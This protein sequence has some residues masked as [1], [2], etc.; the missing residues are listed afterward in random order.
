MKLSQFVAT[1]SLT[2]ILFSSPSIHAVNN[3]PD[4]MLKIM[5]QPKYDHAI[6]GIFV[7]DL[8]TGEVLY[9]QNSA[10]MFSPASTTKLLSISVLLQTLGADYRFKT[11]VYANGGIKDG[12][13]LG[14]LILVAQGDLTMGGRQSNADT[15]SFTKMDHL[16]ANVAPDAIL[17]KEDPLK[18]LDDLAKQVL[19]NGVKE[20]EGDVLIDDRLFETIT[21]RDMILSPIMIN[22]NVIDIVLNPSSIDQTANLMWRPEVPGYSVDNQVKTV[23]KDGPFNIEVTADESGH[24]ILVKGTLPISQHDV[25]KVSPVHDPKA[26]ARDAF[27]QALEKQG[28]KVTIAPKINFHGLPDNYGNQT[29]IALYTSPPLSEYAKL[30]LKVSHNLGADLVPLLLSAHV[31]KKTYDEGMLMI[32][33]FAVNEVKLSPDSFVMMDAAGGNEN[34]FTLQSEIQILEYMHKLA[35]E[36]FKKFYDALPILGVDGSLE[37]FGK[38][39]PAS[40]KVRAKPGTGV[41]SNFATGKLFLITQALAGYIEGKNGHPF[42]YMVVVNNGSLPTINDIFQIFEDQGKLSGILY[43]NT[44]AVK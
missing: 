25:V 13:L 17:T 24:K 30:I 29:K 6:W 16:I 2:A 40:G 43:N 36:E 34:R 4:D 27:I 3:L 39:I 42:A 21:K 19:Q 41:S 12:R 15:I 33:N 37:D 32:G 20:I 28:I 5:Q 1:F 7:K 11:P 31:D 22:E 23:A 8:Q 35:P 9:D 44:G 18:G 10:M 38:G 26:F 14:N